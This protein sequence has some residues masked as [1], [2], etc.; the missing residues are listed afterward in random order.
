VKRYD[1]SFCT[2]AVPE[3]WVPVPPLGLKEP[4]QSKER[5]ELRVAE[6]WL[7]S[8][9]GATDFASQQRERFSGIHQDFVLVREGSLPK[10]AGAFLV[11][12]Y[13]NEEGLI[14]RKMWICRPQGPRV[15]SLT[16]L[17]PGGSSRFRDEVFEAISQTLELKA[18]EFLAQAQSQPLLSNLTGLPI[19]SADPN[20]SLQKFPR[21][22]VA[23]PVPRGWEVSQE[24]N[25]T[26][27]FLRS[28]CEI[29]LRRVVEHAGRPEVWFAET[30]QHL[31]ATPGSLVIA[32]DQ[33]A[34]TD[35]RR[36]AAVLAD[37]TPR[38]RS[39]TTAASS[40][41]LG[42]EIADKQPLEWVLRAPPN[43]FK[44]AQSTLDGLIAGMVF[45]DPEEWETSPAE[46]WVHLTLR[47]PWK[48]QGPGT[49]TRSEPFLLLQL[50]RL[51][52]PP[53]LESLR[54][55]LVDSLRRSFK[56]QRHST[57]Q[58]TPGLFRGL[59]ALR[60]SGRGRSAVQ[61]IWLR[62]EACLYSCLL[63]GADAKR[64]EELFLAV[65][66]GLRLPGMRETI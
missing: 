12:E 57:E 63:T 51:E 64:T 33:G 23:L 49:Y 45:L 47:G 19:P 21:A 18:G 32:Y 27:V 36:Y 62:S 56:V 60:Y 59:E 5:L 48:V 40:R 20:S 4:R 3:D 37:E 11:F 42:V 24:E 43:A 53:A 54:P 2:L 9:V 30:L 31:R 26:I 58:E 10:Q 7:G 55:R 1:F 52:N 8:P 65:V 17:G 14:S 29:R 35:G 44:D 25:G 6:V 39:W 41:V 66:E 13:E 34:L 38:A 61:A 46:T 28:G 22:C 50:S 15:V 16:L